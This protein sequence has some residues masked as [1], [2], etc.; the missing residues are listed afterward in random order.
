MNIQLSP[1]EINKLKDAKEIL[2]RYSAMYSAL[3]K[4]VSGSHFDNAGTASSAIE[5]LLKENEKLEEAK[6]IMEL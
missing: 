2:D 6:T 3:F 4:G 1:R 5:G